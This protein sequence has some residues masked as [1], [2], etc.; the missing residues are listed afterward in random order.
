MI[1]DLREPRRIHLVGAGGAGMGAIAHVLH[2][3]GHTVTGSDLK[4]GAV[5]DRLSVE[6]MTMHVGHDAAHLGEAELVAISTAM[7]PTYLPNIGR[8]VLRHA[9]TGRV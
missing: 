2:T 6:G 4:A 9:G 3:M 5:L 8:R 7:K 1:P